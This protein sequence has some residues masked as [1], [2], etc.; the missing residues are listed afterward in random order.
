MIVVTSD[1]EDSWLNVVSS[2]VLSGDIV[3]AQANV[4]LGEKSG[5]NA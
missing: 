4:V 5:T 3:F 1:E 2:C